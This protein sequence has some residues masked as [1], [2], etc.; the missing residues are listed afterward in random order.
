MILYPGI[1]ESRLEIDTLLNLN[2]LIQDNHHIKSIT[3]C[4]VSGEFEFKLEEL[5]AN[6]EVKVDLVLESTRTLKDVKYPLEFNLDLI[7]G[8]SRDSDY[9]L[10]DKIDL[11]ELVYGHI[12]VYKPTTVYN[13]GEE[14]LVE[15]KQKKVNPA[16]SELKDLKK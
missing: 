11:N 8:T 7:F 2:E 9:I 3:R 14:P 5:I 6:L 15:E 4:H 13:E 10:E 16:F 1:I 12:L